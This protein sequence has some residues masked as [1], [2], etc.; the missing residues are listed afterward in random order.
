MVPTY[1]DEL[2]MFFKHKDMLQIAEEARLARLAMHRDDNRSTLLE[3]AIAK[4]KL[5]IAALSSRPVR[6]AGAP[7]SCRWKIAPNR[8]ETKH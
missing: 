8:H 5:G 3:L 2:V 7:S 1:E 4:F 6:S